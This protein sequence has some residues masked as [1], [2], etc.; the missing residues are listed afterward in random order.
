ML[1]CG[2]CKQVAPEDCGWYATLQLQDQRC[3]SCFIPFERSYENLLQ[4]IFVKDIKVCVECPSYAR[5]LTA[6]VL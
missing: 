4:E 6:S 2:V 3:P 5:C 1:V